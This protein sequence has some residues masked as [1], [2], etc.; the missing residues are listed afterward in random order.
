V[1]NREILS[2]VEVPSLAGPTGYL[3]DASDTELGQLCLRCTVQAE[4][5][6]SL[7]G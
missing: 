5:Q 4:E 3:S 1:S 6:A 2:A 7:G